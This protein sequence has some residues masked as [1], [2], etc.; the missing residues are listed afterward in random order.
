MFDYTR[1]MRRRTVASLRLGSLSKQGPRAVEFSRER[2]W[3]VR[4]YD[5]FVPWNSDEPEF[6][7]FDFTG[8]T[9]RGFSPGMILEL[10][11]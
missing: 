8:S 5:V 3:G 2:L 1:S 4:L 7:V 11:D 10:L 6:G 9:S